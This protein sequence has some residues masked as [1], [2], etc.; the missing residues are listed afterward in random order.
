MPIDRIRDPQGGTET[1]T[2]MSTAVAGE[3]A[4]P[5]PRPGSPRKPRRER[6]ALVLPLLAV[7]IVLS[8]LLRPRAPLG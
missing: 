6:G 2:W 1:F 4:S 7:A 8:G 5:P 3:T